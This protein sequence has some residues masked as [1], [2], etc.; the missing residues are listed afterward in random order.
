MRM[1]LLAASAF[2]GLALQPQAAEAGSV[3]ARINLSSQT[4]TVTED[5]IVK[6]QWKVSTAR[7]GY[8]TPVGSYTAKWLSKN[9][10]SR[11]Y[12]NAPM[13]YS[14]FFKGGYAVHGTTELKRLGTPASHGCVRLDPKNAAALFAMTQ[15]NGLANTRIVI[16]R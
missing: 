16:A 12:N 13:P 3:V 9:H 14:I 7:K 11:K 5:G 2:V 1:L 10:R 8:V 4:M 15:R 6:Y